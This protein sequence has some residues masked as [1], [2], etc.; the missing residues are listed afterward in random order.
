LNQTATATNTPGGL[1]FASSNNTV[2]QALTLFP[3][4]H[5]FSDEFG[6]V[7]NSGYEALQ[8]TIQPRAARGLTFMLTYT[9]SKTIDDVGTFRSGYAIP[10]GMVEGSSKAYPMDRIDRSL[11]LIDLPQNLTFTSVYDLPFGKGHWGG[12]NPFFSAVVRGWTLSDIFTYVSGNP[13]AITGSSCTDPGQGQCMPSYAPGFSGSARQNGAWGHGAT[14][15][16]LAKIQYVNP[17]AFEATPDYEIGNLARTGAYGLRGHGNYDIDGTLRR[18]FNILPNERVKLEF[19]ADVF[20]AVNHVWFGSTSSN[21]LG[22]V[23]QGFSSSP[24]ASTSLGIVGG[25]A[26]LPH[27]SQFEA[28]VNF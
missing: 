19:D 1:P 7:G 24:A 22:N 9:C 10:A 3:Q 20:N 13:L 16:T 26:N 11:S 8:L 14:A 21:A 4:Y 17:N 12:D 15:A 27:Q 28:H 18:T 6:S 5:G 25:Q 23:G 2:E